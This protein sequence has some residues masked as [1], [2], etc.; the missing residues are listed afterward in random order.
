VAVGR[1]GHRRARSVASDEGK[2]LLAIA[3]LDAAPNQ[4]FGQSFNA[5]CDTN[6]RCDDP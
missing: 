2:G 3:R 6:S 1:L 5:L 4:P